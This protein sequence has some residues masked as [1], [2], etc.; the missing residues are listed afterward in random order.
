M[1]FVIP[2]K[3]CEIVSKTNS[4]GFD[5]YI[6]GGAV[7][8]LIMG[9]LLYDWDFT[10]NA[11]PSQIM[12]IF[13]DSYYDNKYGTVGM[14]Y[15]EGQRPFE[16]T[17]FRSENGYS[18]LRRPDNISW[19]KNLE[20]DLK[21]RDFT[22]N[23][24]AMKIT[25]KKQ[26]KISGSKSE[27]ELIDLFGGQDDLN[28]KLIRAVG[29]PDQRFSEDALR[30]MRA[31]RIA[32]ELNFSIEKNTL[33]AINNNANLI[34]KIAAERIREELF[35][36]LKSA[37]PYEGMTLL[38]ESGLMKIILPE[39]F[40]CFGV[41]QKSPNRHHIFDVGT[42]SMMALKHCP[43]P[44]PVVRL[45]TLMHD[46]G[47]AK[48]RKVKDDGTVTFYA[49]QIV[50]ARIA[51]NIGARLKFSAKDSDRFWKLIRFHMFSVDEKQTDSAL[52]RFIK[53]VGVENLS[54]ILDL[55][56]GDRLGSGASLTSWRLEEFKK[57][58]IEIQKQPFTVKDLKI[59]GND[60][61]KILQI[62]PGPK[63]G[64]TL[65]DLFEKVVEKKLENKKGV[66]ISEI[67]KLL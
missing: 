43:S 4:K 51:K 25:T 40:E 11:T 31:I 60:I 24:M 50:S 65:Q 54:D 1:Q 6:V 58:L 29:N 10:T 23:A 52:R 19:G 62:K 57:R 32:S 64:Q 15:E 48:T 36:I 47:K 22:I 18:D 39:L 67:K 13:P 53:N 21:R 16:I 42:H 14:E 37:H 30:M 2:K 61:M 45:A 35:K 59:N 9:R 34:N 26:K 55:R 63:V 44:D 17:T 3:V 41:D 66:L 46:A 8:D 38:K 20:E 7:R 12:E 33:A 49:H 28:N 27:V 56:I 5:I